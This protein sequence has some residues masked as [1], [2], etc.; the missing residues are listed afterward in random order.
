MRLRDPLRIPK[1]L[2][3]LEEYWHRFP[4]MRLGQIVSNAANELEMPVY[5]MEDEELI[6]YLE[7]KT[8]ADPPTHS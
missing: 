2:A 4:D 3:L 6:Q 1:I 8:A 7:S 5:Y